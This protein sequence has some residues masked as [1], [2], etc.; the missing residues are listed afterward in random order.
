MATVAAPPTACKDLLRSAQ[1]AL[2]GP[3]AP[4]T[5]VEDAWRSYLQDEAAVARTLI[6]GGVPSAERQVTNAEH[7]ASSALAEVRQAVSAAP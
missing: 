1:N 3:A 7:S 2:S 5:I 4:V 6:S